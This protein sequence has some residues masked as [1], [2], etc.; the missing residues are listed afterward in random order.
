MYIQTS[1]G[2]MLQSELDRICVRNEELH[3]NSNEITK[4]VEYKLEGVVIKRSV[5]THL[6]QGLLSGLKLG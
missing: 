5:H 2:P 1:L 4:V 3:E 6:K